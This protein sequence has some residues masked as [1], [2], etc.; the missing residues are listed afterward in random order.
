[1]NLRAFALIVYLFFYLLL[2]FPKRLYYKKLA[3][4]DPGKAADLS[5]K[6]IASACRTIMR[7]TGSKVEVEGLDKIPDE[8]VLFVGNHTSYFD[9]VTAISTL[10]HATGFVAKDVIKKVPGLYGWMQRINCLYLDRSDIKKGVQMI[11][12]G[13]E[14]INQ[15]YSMFIYPEGTRSTTG[16]LLPFRGGALKMAQRSGAPVVPVA[17]SGTRDIYENNKGLRIRPSNVRIV[18]GEPFR[19]QDLPKEQKRFA[20]DYTRSVLEDLLAD[21]KTGEEAGG[22]NS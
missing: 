21:G 8:A 4:K 5:F 15:G 18:Y 2:T 10:P 17:I 16:E 9:I 11:K 1:M 13:I 19:I 14:N 6:N 20:A 22:G 7:I 3:K 12:D